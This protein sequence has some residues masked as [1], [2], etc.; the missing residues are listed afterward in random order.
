MDARRRYAVARM[1]MSPSATT[2][3]DPPDT[4]AERPPAGEAPRVTGNCPNC[5]A[6]MYGD[7]CYAC[8]Q[9]KKGLIR[10]FSSIIGDFLDTVLNID[11]RI[12][13]TLAPLFF[14]PGYLTNEY[15]DGR[16]ASY[17]TPLR[18]Y[19]F[20]SIIA[21]VLIGSLS[22]GDWVVDDDGVRV[23]KEQRRSEMA[24]LA[25]AERQARIK[26]IEKAMQYA[27]D[28]VR[29]EVI[30]DMRAEAGRL[31][32][33]EAA[34]AAMRAKAA[35]EAAPAASAVS[36]RD[37]R[38]ESTPAMATAKDPPDPVDPTATGDATNERAATPEVAA[39][40]AARARERN[41]GGRGESTDD[42]DSG[43]GPPEINL[44][45]RIW[46]REANPLVVSWLPGFANEV[47][48]DQ[49]EEIAS[50]IGDIK[51]N[52]KPFVQQIFASAP[53]ALFVILPLFA[54]MLKVFYVFKR[55]LYME[56]LIVAL[57]SHSFLCFAIIMIVALE[58][59]RGYFGSGFMHGLLG[60]VMGAVWCW[61]P[62]YLFLMQKRVYRQGWIMTTLKYIMI[63]TAYLFLL[64]FGLLLTLAISLI[65]L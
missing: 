31:D 32:A 23:G 16:R 4:V 44:N 37:T 35:P 11:N 41:E 29:R 57:H 3:D 42:D 18:L 25:P 60:W 21:F 1:S 28:E 46:D 40:R 27:P 38:D 12:F 14:K 65:V 22:G 15:L 59:A 58:R 24:E 5:G 48:N 26:E 17:V 43:D 10:H 56:H 30:A 19:F 64:A 63:G 51:R 53:Q 20:L 54:L 55:R 52:P 9:P 33:K 45:G 6:P 34:A 50:K 36:E 7:F 47:L 61:M 2:P 49:I 8:G 39:A 13:R 62:I